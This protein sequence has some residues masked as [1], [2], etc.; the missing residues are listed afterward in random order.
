MTGG[1]FII[2]LSLR[3]QAEMIPAWGS[4]LTVQAVEVLHAC[5]ICCL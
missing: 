2:P 5:Q 3:V 1:V 4:S